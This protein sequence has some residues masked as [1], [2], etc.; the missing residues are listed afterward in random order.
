L[1]NAILKRVVFVLAGLCMAGA[2][3][4]AVPADPAWNDRIAEHAAQ[5]RKTIIFDGQSPD[6]LACDT[7][8]RKM[9]DG[10]WVMVMLGGGD[11]EPHPRN[12]VFITRSHDEGE[13]WSKMQRIDFGF[14]YKGDTKAKV[15]TELMVHD[16]RCTLMF[17][18]HDGKFGGWK[19]WMASSDDSCRTWSAPVPAPGRLHERTFIRNH[20]V[21]RDGRIILPFQHYVDGP[22]PV[23][24]RNGVLISKNGGKTW[25][26][27]GDIRLTGND[28]YHGWAENN[29]VE[30]SDGRIAMIIRADR[31]GGVLYYAESKDGGKTWPKRAR[32]T[33]IPNPGSKATLYPL[34]GD[35]VALL[36]NPNPKHRSPLSLWV[37]FDG[38]QTWPYQRVL[39]PESVDG[40]RGRL[41]YPDGFVSEDGQWL[42]FA[43]DDNRH[44]AVYY[45]AKLPTK[46]LEKPELWDSS[47]PLP[48]SE[49]VPQLKDVTFHEIKKRDVEADG[50]NWLHGVA[51][52][53]HKGRLYSSFG[54]NAGHENTGSEVAGWTVSDDA[55]KTWSDVR[56]IDDGSEAGN[57]A[58]SHGVFYS[59]EGKLWA[60]MGS[61]FGRRSNVHMRA[62]VLDES[63]GQW[64]AR[65]RVAGGGFW[66]M[67]EP[68]RMADG[69]HILAGLI[70]GEGNPAAVAISHGDDLTRWDIVKIPRP[71]GMKM[72]G[73][74]TVIVDGARVLN[75]SRYRRP[76]ALVSVSE[77][78]GRT[79]T[80]MRESNLKMTASK[81]YAGKLST[82]HNFLVC[83]TTAD[84]GNRRSP[85]TI[86]IAPPGQWVFEKVYTI[87]TAEHD[88]VGES[89]PK[90]RLSYPYAVERDGKLYIGYSNEGGRVGNRNSAELAIIPIEQLVS[91]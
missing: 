37:S 80:T 72:W 54:L 10:S 50:Y 59:H 36:H 55:G 89:H 73:E 78:Y 27:H 22:G 8:L 56:V 91:E 82:G 57:H 28:N 14:P 5:D 24:P 25:I 1:H 60:F 68:I 32:K 43:F 81:P 86:A 23:N 19:T 20:I 41:N 67:Q 58:V 26:E 40:P 30:L 4:G 42:H 83:T 85:L 16:G 44:Q 39:V 34:G 47:R 33:S 79:W 71:D 29:V 66:P 35:T 2:C 13:T 62:Y 74:S 49:D 53:W 75:I 48:K 9:P 6:K 61:F 46:P 31:L 76:M 15:P 3:R 77:D 45:G 88:G 7:T 65:G 90:A 52:A 63:S 38:L 17:A 18:T 69:N 21:T 51:L 12:G 87:R 64:Q 84:A 11:R 70:C